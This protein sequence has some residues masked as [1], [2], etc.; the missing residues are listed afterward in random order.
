MHT[1]EF[2]DTCACI[3]QL[4]QYNSYLGLLC[5]IPDKNINDRFINAAKEEASRIFPNSPVKIIYPP[6][7]KYEDQKILKIK[8][9]AERI[10]C[11]ACIADVSSSPIK[12]GNYSCG[13]LVWWQ[14]EPAFPIDPNVVLAVKGLKWASFAY[15]ACY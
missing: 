7:I 2:D 5:G 10:P 11:V 3:D 9:D 12:D 13:V 4:L 14:E 1:I 15:D 6:C 8:P